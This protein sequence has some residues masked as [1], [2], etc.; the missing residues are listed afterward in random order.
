MPTAIDECRFL[1]DGERLLPRLGPR[2]P[3]PK[4]DNDGNPEELL[5][6]AAEESDSYEEYE[7]DCLQK[8]FDPPLDREGRHVGL[9]NCDERVKGVLVGD[10]EVSGMLRT[11]EAVI[12]LQMANRDH[13]LVRQCPG[14]L[15]YRPT[16]EDPPRFT[17]GVRAEIRDQHNLRKFDSAQ[18]SYGRPMAFVHCTHDL[19]R[20]FTSETRFTSDASHRL[21]E[22][23][24]TILSGREDT[25]V[26][27]LDDQLVVRAMTTPGDPS[28]HVP[29]IHQSLF[30]TDSGAISLLEPPSLDATREKLTRTVVEERARNL[31]YGKPST[32]W[33]W[34][35]CY[36]GPG[37]H[38]LFE[39][40]NIEHGEP[41]LL[42]CVV[43]NLQGCHEQ[44]S[45]AA[46]RVCKHFADRMRKPG[47]DVT[48]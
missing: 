40:S 15:L 21:K 16:F 11:L 43:D 25:G 8:I 26:G 45:A 4:K 14:F 32:G 27:T 38:C 42:A 33:Q 7:A 24:T 36:L 3:L 48:E 20:M 44:R 30:L 13:L 10:S 9:P 5:F 29:A 39:Q 41:V 1:K 6:S 19:Q 31:C 46:A 2:W 23:A 17:G 18:R 37:G 47:L 22:A 12:R 34:E 35:Y 28:D